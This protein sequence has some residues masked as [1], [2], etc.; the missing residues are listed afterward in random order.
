MRG[1]FS[2]RSAIRS[3]DKSTACTWTRHNLVAYVVLIVVQLVVLV[4]GPVVA[5]LIGVDV[6][7]GCN[8]E[9]TVYT[10]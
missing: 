8:Q 9:R 10:G 1:L 5:L 3:D 7:A 6:T 2:S 4:D